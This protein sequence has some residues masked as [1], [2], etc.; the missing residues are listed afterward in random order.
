M[1]LCG[2]RVFWLPLQGFSLHTKCLVGKNLQFL[3]EILFMEIIRL[4]CDKTEIR[5]LLLLVNMWMKST[6]SKQL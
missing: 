3:M 5:Y 6:R 2:I 1:Y 4:P